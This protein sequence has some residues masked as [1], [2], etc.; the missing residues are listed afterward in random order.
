M[1]L[2]P[3]KLI[4]R[5]DKSAALRLAMTWTP[6]YVQMFCELK[7]E[8]G[9]VQFQNRFTIFR[10]KIAAYV[11]LYDDERKIGSLLLKGLLGE[12]GSRNFCL[13]SAQWSEKELSEFFTYICGA[14]GGQEFIDAFN[15]P[16]SEEEWKRREE[17]FHT[18]SIDEKAKA[19]TREI[20]FFA[21]LFGQMFNTLALMTHGAKL[22]T[23][24]PL[25]IAGNDDALLKAAQVDRY[26]LTHH[27]Y[28]V[29]R[30][31]KAQ[32]NGEIE[33][34]RKLAVRETNP[35]LSGRIQYPGLFM[36]FGVLESLQ[37]LDDLSHVEILDL[38][39]EMG[40][41]R[42]QNRIEDT[43]SLTKR[44]LAYRRFQK[45]GGVSMH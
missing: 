42:Y 31:R 34:L 14:E 22:T 6:L 43:N 27:P 13:E 8:G 26:L 23:L 18:L 15:F 41:D 3:D 24:V 7:N 9:R 45:T 21:G 32:D 38:C 39:D 36:L 1:A 44:L 28:F 37:W 2:D 11:T 19:T 16:D 35:N 12:E 29:E 40:L 4:V 20:C 30:K 33:F 10:E 25:A 5:P 17:F